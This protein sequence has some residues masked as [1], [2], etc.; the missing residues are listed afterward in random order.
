M[1]QAKLPVNTGIHR[2]RPNEK[3]STWIAL[4]WLSEDLIL[5]SGLSGELL[6]W[7]V[8]VSYFDRRT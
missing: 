3:R 4:Q 8:K 6:A 7:N 1:T 2:P 5:S